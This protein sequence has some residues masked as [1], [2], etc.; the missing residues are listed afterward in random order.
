MPRTNR[1]RRLIAL[2]SGLSALVAIEWLVGLLSVAAAIQQ[3]RTGPWSELSNRTW[4][5]ITDLQRWVTAPVLWLLLLG[6]LELP[7][8]RAGG[9]S[10]PVVRSEPSRPSGE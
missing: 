8:L 2:L 3:S 7:A 6:K 5:E 9:T 4:S 10:G 1:R